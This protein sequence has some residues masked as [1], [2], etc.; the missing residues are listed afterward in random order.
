VAVSVGVSV[1]VAVGVSVGVAVAVAVGLAVK[2]WVG[3]G[4]SL[5]VSVG[6][7]DPVVVGTGVSVGVPVG[8]SVGASVG[9]D[10]GV[11]VF[12]GVSVGVTVG[13]SVGVSSVSC[14]GLALAR[15][16][17]GVITMSRN[18]TPRQSCH[19]P[20][21]AT[22]TIPC[23]RR[24]KDETTCGGMTPSTK[25]AD[26]AASGMDPRRALKRPLTNRKPRPRLRDSV[27]LIR[28]G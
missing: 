25:S 5:G 10:V 4:V 6:V 15:L 28:V 8:V 12:V 24:R 2:V 21:M 26:P 27:H 1:E 18:N 13:V 11:S 19:R 14:K 9:V 7:E 20:Y 23:S 22:V 3:D 16:S 17:G